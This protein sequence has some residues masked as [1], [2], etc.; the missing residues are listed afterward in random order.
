MPTDP[1]VPTDPDARPRQ[2]QNLPPGVTVPP[3]AGWRADRPGDGTAGTGAL[4]GTPGPNVGYAYSLARRAA[5]RFRLAL[6]ESAEDVV[7]V[8]AELAGRRAAAFGRGPT[9]T[10]VEHAAAILGYD[11]AADPEWARARA[12]LV[13]EAGHLYVRRRALVDAV[14]DALLFAVGAPSAGDVAACRT[15]LTASGH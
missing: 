15:A 14:P 1:F 11:R 5:E 9:M 10:D 2:Q 13:H 4:L 7:P 3:A 8:V 12:R 6:H